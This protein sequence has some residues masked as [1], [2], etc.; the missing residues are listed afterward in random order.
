MK[1][2]NRKMDLHTAKLITSR[3]SMSPADRLVIWRNS[4]IT[5][6][7]FMDLPDA[8]YD[9]PTWACENGHISKRYLKSEKLGDVCLACSKP[10]LLVP[11]ETTEEKLAEMLAI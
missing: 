9:N 3:E 10:I 4:Q 8:W 7:L 11:T 1:L 6:E 5:G 2:N